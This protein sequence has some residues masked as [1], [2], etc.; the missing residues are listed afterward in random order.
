MKLDVRNDAV[1]DLEM[2]SSGAG[3]ISVE[4][5]HRGYIEFPVTE[6]DGL[7]V[8]GL[9]GRTCK[10]ARARKGEKEGR[11]PNRQIICWPIVHSR[12]NSKTI[13]R[14]L[15]RVCCPDLNQANGE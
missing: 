5:L 12:Y 10:R 8:I 3:L 4:L 2:G 13:Q 14:V 7:R 15:S 11:G 9:E 1:V 6:V